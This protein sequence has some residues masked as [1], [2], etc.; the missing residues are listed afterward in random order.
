MKW[1][2]TFNLV[3]RSS[4]S[5]LREKIENPE[6]MLHQLLIDMEEELE[7]VRESVAEAIADEIELGGRVERARGDSRRWEERAGRALRSGE[8]ASSRAALEQK[9]AMDREAD[10]LA[11]E[12]DEQRAQTARLQASVR[13]LERKIRQARQRRTLLLARM[14]RAESS[15]RIQRAMER[16]SEPSA[17]AEFSRL[18]RKVE[19]SEARSVAYDR[20]AGRDP[21]AGELDARFEEEETRER[22]EQALADLKRRVGEKE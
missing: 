15:V 21:A 14:A 3:V 20:L 13:D 11:A 12:F 4:L 6:R 16:A 17:F 22:I 8:E 2:S 5:S 9:I 1:L 19:R 10:G 7:H 18:E